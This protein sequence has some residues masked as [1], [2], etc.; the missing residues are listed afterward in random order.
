VGNA[1]GRELLSGE[2]DVLVCDGFTGNIVLKFLE[3][4]A[5]TILG[6]LKGYIME[7]AAQRLAIPL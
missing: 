6:M 7:S 1:E 2:F 3:G 5:K 4:C